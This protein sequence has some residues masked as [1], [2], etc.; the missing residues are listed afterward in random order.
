MLEFIEGTTLKKLLKE[1]SLANND[2]INIFFEILIAVFYIHSKSFICR[3]FNL[4]NFIID[5][6]K[7]T[8]IID[9]DRI[10]SI[11]DEQI[12]IDFNEVPP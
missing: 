5:E 4:N 11:N 8:F 10:L 2:K 6:D 3:D 7:N 12:T 1:G 9:F